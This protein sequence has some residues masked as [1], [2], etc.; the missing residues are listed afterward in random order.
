MNHAESIKTYLRCLETADYETLISLF[1][2][3]AVVHSPLYGDVPAPKFYKDLF[4]DTAESKITPLNVF[5]SENPNVAAAHFQFDWTLADG[6]PVPFEVVDV[7]RFS[8]DGKVKE[9]KIIYDSA[10]TKP[11]F[12]QLNS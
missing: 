4:E 3:D 9:L 5:T 7:F 2:D 10:K 6:T 1:A 8:D 11:A 12:D